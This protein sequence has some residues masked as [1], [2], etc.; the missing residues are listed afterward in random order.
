[1]ALGV[2]SACI[3]HL[4]IEATHRCKQ[5]G[6]PVCGACVVPAPTGNFCSEPCRDSYQQFAERAEELERNAP[7]PKRM[8]RSRRFVLR[9]C[10]LVAVAALVVVLATYMG[11]DVPVVGEFVKQILIAGS[12]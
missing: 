5:C 12:D 11:F 10:I 4:S 6:R 3:N 8:W 7:K 9:L 2:E 1:V